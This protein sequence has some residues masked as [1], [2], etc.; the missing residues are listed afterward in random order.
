MKIFCA[1]RSVILK[2]IVVKSFSKSSAMVKYLDQQEAINIDNELF[3]EYQFTVDQLMELAGLSCATAIAKTYS[4]LENKSILVCCGPGNNGG[5]GLVCA[6]HLKL[7]DFNPII[8][9]PQPN[10]K[11]LFNRLTNQC[12]LMDIPIIDCTP[13]AAGIEEEFS[14]I[15]D[16]IFGFSFKPPIRRTFV[17]I[18]DYMKRTKLPIISI[19]IPSGWDVNE[20]KPD[21][22]IEPEMLISLT[23]PKKCAESFTGKYH[24]LGGRFVPKRLQ[25]KYNLQLPKYVGTELCVALH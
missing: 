4:N 15:V 9:C 12:F 19:D 17:P 21:G 18:I 1:V 16:A 13:E 14:F 23:A 7:F 24:F 3:N 2:S 20:G 22:G 11:E 25:D 10:E 6:R 5:D 8:C